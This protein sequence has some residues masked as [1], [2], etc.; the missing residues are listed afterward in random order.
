VSVLSRIATGR[1]ID[2]SFP[3]TLTLEAASNTLDPYFGG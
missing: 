2:N 1:P 3:D